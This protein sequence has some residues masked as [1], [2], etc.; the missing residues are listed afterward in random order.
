MRALAVVLALALVGG[1]LAVWRL[2]P[3]AAT[4]TLV[5]SGSS[6]GRATDVVHARF[7]DDAVYVLVRGD[8]ARLVLTSDLN[9]LLGLEGCLA[10]NVPSGAAVP[11]G[12]SGP[13]AGLARM[14][15]VR[16]V[17]GPGTFINSSVEELTKQLQAQ[18]RAR[19]AQADRANEAARKLA[20]AEGRS[21]AEAKRLGKQAEQLVYAQFARDLLALNAKYGLNLTGAPKLNDPDFVYS[22]VF[23]P[24]RGAREPKARFAYLFPS[25]DSALVSVRLKAGLSDSERARAVALIRAA[26]AMP[27]WKLDGGGRYV[28][29]GVPVLAGD[30]T[31][32]LASSTLRLLLVAVAVMALVLALLFRARLR[33]LPLGLALC[34]VAILFGALTLLGLPLTM[35][36]IAVLPVLMGLAVDY[37]IQYQ[38]R[39]AAVRSICTAALATAVGFLVLL[40]SPVPM[41]RGFG[42][43]LVVGVGVSL[44]VALTAGTAVMVLAARRRGSSGPVARSLRGAGELFDGAARGVAT[45]AAGAGRRSRRGSAAVWAR[46][47][48][49]APRT[50]AP[51][52]ASFP[53]EASAPRGASAPRETSAPRGAPAPR[54]VAAALRLFARHPERVLVVAAALA[55]C[56]W[57]LDARIGVVSD[58]PRLVPQDLAAV[59]DLDALQKDTGVA[60]EVDV[61]V[62][63]K[64]LT[65]PKMIAWMRAYQQELL[66]RHGYNAQKGCS[67]GELCP[68]LSLPDLFRTPALSAT[69]EQIRALLD[70]VPPYFSQAAVT[71]DR[72]TAVLAFG[73]RLQSLEAQRA[74]IQ[75]MRARL[76]PPAG[77]TA[78]V[79][80]LPVLVADANHA[81]SDPL[82]RALTALA[83]LVAVALALFAVYRSWA[84]AWVPLV[85]IA[86]A[87][88][89]SALV[90]WLL[91]I[92][93]NPMSAAL[94]ALVIAIST[95]FSVLLSA[96]YRE[97][98]EA[99]LAPPD[100][101]T[102]T[103][104]STGAAV[105]ASGVTALAGF[106]VLIAS[107]VA[108]LRDFGLVTVIDLAVS[109]LG[110]LAVL[111]A[112]L[113]AAEQRTARR[114][115]RSRAVA[116]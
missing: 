57:A 98:R 41:V 62:E 77:V 38:A 80:G 113:V 26:V 110:V 70:A 107:D 11:G 53:R 58:L 86:L 21:Q 114:R 55:I 33:L 28:V 93:L 97:E 60:G 68:A 85:P 75:D 32:V 102:A 12:A 101:L 5:G 17:Y 22:L 88:G 100:A 27:D 74:V 10:G 67:G 19:A 61:L 49:R 30:L 7:G 54:G 51:R 78:T 63:A 95:E 23:D 82:R 39:P 44:A 43:L 3:S 50:A 15:P 52:G 83:G 71:P 35:A 13:C 99:G 40:L 2:S 9:R 36:S 66:T 24:A 45:G 76:H 56:G 65:D 8:L 25:A 96:R 115:A 84:R 116:A 29:T 72:K 87:T 69:R 64:D 20:L 91:G 4:S 90:L 16:V 92:P 73:I 34:A 48:R 1:G 6:A 104:A 109:L 42:A 47:R 31:D 59:R 103:Y 111:P 79:A 14:K 89:W 46:L 106:A 81:L 37:G 18:T 108:M 94:S 105:L 112:V